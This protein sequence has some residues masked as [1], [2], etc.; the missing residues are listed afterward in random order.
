MLN[1]DTGVDDVDGGS[2]AGSGVVDVAVGA[3]GLVGDAA[4]TPGGTLA[5]LEGIGVDL[6]ILLNPCDLVLVSHVMHVGFY[7]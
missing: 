6:S 5:G 1:V 4:K 7:N 3:G 2:L